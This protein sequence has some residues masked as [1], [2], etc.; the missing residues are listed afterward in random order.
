PYK[1]VDSVVELFD[2]EKTLDPLAKEVA[3]PLWKKIFDVHH[4]NREYYFVC[5][6]MFSGGIQLVAEQMGTE[7][8]GDLKPIQ[9]NR[10]FARIVAIYDETYHVDDNSKWEHARILEDVEAVKWLVSVAPQFEQSSHFFGRTADIILS[11]LSSTVFGIIWLRQVSVTFLEQQITNSPFLERIYLVKSDDRWPM[12]V[13]PLLEQFC[14]KGRP[15]RHVYLEIRDALEAK[16]DMNFIQRLFEHWKEN[17]TLNFSLECDATVDPED[18]KTLLRKGEV[19]ELEPNKFQSVF[20]HHTEKSVA[21]CYSE[22]YNN[23]DFLEFRTCECDL[24]R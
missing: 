3:H 21:V 24:L 2:G 12:S 17:G 18:W 9:E 13:L 4:R 15:G 16:I 6:R 11:S 22:D 7:I 23:R 20:K 14:L 1:F 5:I 8:Y 19:T 10:R